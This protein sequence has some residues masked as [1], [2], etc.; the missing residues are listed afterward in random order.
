MIFRQE[1][2]GYVRENPND[3]F[4]VN[5]PGCIQS[6]YA[7]AHEYGDVNYGMNFRQYK[8]MEDLYWVY[9]TKLQ[10]EQRKS[11][12]VFFVTKGIDYEYDIVLNGKKILNHEGMFSSVE[13]DITDCL[14][15]DNLLQVIIYPMP[16]YNNGTGV[17]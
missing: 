7:A 14:T 15:E 1:W 4:K 8:W 6:D 3:K 2:I 13:I 10:Y 9:E 12:R 17:I 11:E 5:V 16:K